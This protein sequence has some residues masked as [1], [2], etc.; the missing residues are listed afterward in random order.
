MEFK[1]F[2]QKLAGV[3]R[4]SSNTAAF[5]KSIF[6]AILPE[7]R[8][9]LLEGYKESTFKGFY[10][11]HAKI[12]KLSRKINNVA[13]PIFFENY[14]RT[15][16]DTAIE[17]LC[18]TFSNDIPNINLHNACELIASLFSTIITCAASNN[19]KSVPKDTDLPISGTNI[20]PEIT[21]EN[22]NNL[23]VF[24][25]SKEIELNTNGN[26]NS[27]NNYIKAATA[28][29]STK[30][31]LLYA[32]KPHPFYELYVCNNIKQKRFR[33]AG[34]QSSHTEK[35]ISN[36]TIEILE[37]ESNYIIIQG[38]GGIGKSMLLTHLFLSSSSQ[39]SKTPILLSLK[40]YKDSTCGMVD[41]IWKS[42]SE[43]DTEISQTNI[44]NALRQKNIILL[45]DGLDEIQSSMKDNFNQDLEAFIKSYPGNTTII[46]SRPVNSFVS[47]SK[48]SLFDIQEL[49]KNQAIELI[50]KL[51]FWDIDG[52]KKFLNDLKN[53]LFYTHK[54][55]A[56]NPLLL[57][58]MLMTYSYF[59]EVPAK[60]HVFYSKAYETMARLHDATKGSFKRPLHTGLT[61]E[62]FSKY[63]AEFC[64]RTY[65]D[66]LL[67]Y[68]CIL[69]TKYMNKVL[70]KSIPEHQNISPRAFLLDL[71]DNLCIMYHEGETFY[72][73]H[74]SFQEYFA[75]LH[76]A[77]VYDENLV[78]VGHY[79][80]KMSTR[81]YTDR[82][83]E[84]LYDM[85][86]EKIERFI[87]LPFLEKLL[88]SCAE[89]GTDEYWEFLEQ[90]Y[91][92][93][94][95][96]EGNTGVFYIN[97]STSFLYRRIVQEKKI[98]LSS[99]LDDHIWPKSI[100]NLPTKI[101]V[102][103]YREFLKDSAY[104]KYPNPD[105]IPENLLEDT[106]LVLR[107]ELP[108]KYHE[109]F[110]DPDEE[111][112]TIEIN[113]DD[114]RNNPHRYIELREHMENPDFPLFREFQ[115]I[116]QY[117]ESLKLRIT[118]ENNSDDL[119]ND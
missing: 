71:T 25:L 28:F 81:S 79:F 74:R 65:M 53:K 26:Y 23:F 40:D 77:S 108:Y 24:D 16:E 12:N 8:Y 27:F 45:M 32:E 9:D 29:Y 39:T 35:V 112:I 104:D 41:F 116:K 86:P 11:G 96:E 60:M 76:F 78:K 51:E 107:E 105:D 66:E 49:T 44:I 113:I 43:Y 4:G 20:A 80:E 117:Y 89:K 54:Q 6:E 67:E 70:K 85:I 13:D 83:F 94:N 42:V 95:Y 90:I 57:T 22:A 87:F 63:F 58:I 56:S 64:A 106:S 21:A 118:S 102:D 88:T 72:F 33:T 61:P 18:F 37:Q 48:F 55:F 62:E 46:T 97:D 34:P 7:D 30:K 99:E 5:T 114:L 3:L 19:K 103:A 50:E 14:L 31:T 109:Y 101:W 84:M 2:V 69:F 75:A 73:I 91:P 119:F 17:K 82:T 38:I 59:G 92:Y 15:Q 52:K 1:Y 111:G 115:N 100:Y 93:L 68:D 98:S 36:V 10:N 110:G 47:F